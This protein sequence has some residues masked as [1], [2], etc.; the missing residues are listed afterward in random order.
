VSIAA[1]LLVY[2]LAVL[3]IGP[4]LLRSLTRS[5]LAPRLGVAAWLTA[6]SSVLL[7]W[8]LVVALSIA[9]VIRIW[10]HPA[11]MAT[12]CVARLLGVAAGDSGI[13]PQIPLL[14]LV[15]FA[16]AAAV[17]TG[18]RLAR[19]MARMRAH[20]REHA[21]AVRL[22]GLRT[23]APD[24][25]VIE[26][27][28]PAAYCVTGR[29][30]AIVVTS[31]AVA[32]LDQR[33]LAAVLAH[34]RAH[35][36][37][38]HWIVVS[39]LRGLAAAFPRLTLMTEGAQ[40][41]SRLLEMCADDAAARQHDSRA[42]LSALTTLCRAAPAVALAAADVAVVARAERLA[43]SPA[44]SDKTRARAALTGAVAILA[45]GPVI[46]TALATVGAVICGF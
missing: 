2:S 30:P 15:V 14:A 11:V 9:Q 26:A 38:H 18:V 35:L 41:V 5:G 31:A 45:A 13:A 34:E 27:A 46:V 37:G 25:V 17:V 12:S 33:Q 22:V 7:T 43:I 10:P 36:S 3:T 23:G 29:P 19:S 21:Y 32:A 1:C 24:I 42:L 16:S 39:A 40:Q 6:I 44:R 20:A 28:K 4:R 8:L